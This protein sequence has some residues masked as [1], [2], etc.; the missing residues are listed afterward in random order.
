MKNRNLSKVLLIIGWTSILY[1][2]WLLDSLFMTTIN[3]PGTV[4]DTFVFLFIELLSYPYLYVGS[5]LI[6]L[7]KRLNPNDMKAENKEKNKS[8]VEGTITFGWIIIL[9][10]SI[11]TLLAFNIT[12]DAEGQAYRPLL[13]TP[14]VIGIVVGLLIIW[15]GMRIQKKN[16]G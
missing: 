4:L 5:F 6:W 16:N 2:V 9:F 11:Y 12:N 10:A 13:V 8:V 1:N 15:R 14:G 3:S 7:A